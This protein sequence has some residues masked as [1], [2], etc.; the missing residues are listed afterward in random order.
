MC[1]GQRGVLTSCGR[2]HLVQQLHAGPFPDL[3]D[4][5]PQF[6]IGLFQVPCG[7]AQADWQLSP[8]PPV[9]WAGP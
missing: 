9:G 6:L 8:G 4:D 7:G 3:L 2:H 5:G 1:P